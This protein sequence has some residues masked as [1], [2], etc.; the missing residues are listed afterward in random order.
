MTDFLLVILWDT[1]LPLIF[2]DIV[3]DSSW[4]DFPVNGDFIGTFPSL[5]GI[6]IC[7]ESRDLFPNTTENWNMKTI[8]VCWYWI[9]MKYQLEGYIF[10]Q[11]MTG[12]HGKIE[13]FHDKCK[14]SHDKLSNF[15]GNTR[16]PKRFV[17]VVV[18]LFYFFCVCGGGGG[19]GCVC[20]WGGVCV[21]V[22]VKRELYKFVQ[23][24]QNKE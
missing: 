15:K 20:V 13:L 16:T 12:N 9:S 23:I 5:S 4:D 24:P 7:V 10:H 14:T 17:V 22:C 8:K 1:V 21:C 2:P 19:C 11:V 18:V 3:V 6:F